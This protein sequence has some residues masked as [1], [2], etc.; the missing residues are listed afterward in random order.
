M[1]LAKLSFIESQKGF[2]SL[3][4]AKSITHLSA[5]NLIKTLFRDPEITAMNFENPIAGKNKG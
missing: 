2:T 4:P 3:V 1:L 5:K